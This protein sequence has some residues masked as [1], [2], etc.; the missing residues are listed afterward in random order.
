MD[1]RLYFRAFETEDLELINRLRNDDYVYELTSGNKYYVSS[2]RDER[3]IED[4]ILNNFS[5]LY[6]MICKYETN[7]PIGYIA[8]TDIDYVNRKAK[9]GGIVISK[10]HSHQGFGTEATELM[11]EHMFDELG[12]NMLY[13]FWREDHTSSIKM[14]EKTGFAI[15]GLITDYVYKQGKFHNAYLMTIT[16]KDYNKKYKNI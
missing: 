4:K 2:K 11:F 1:R 9:Y 7:E 14:A 13:G 3:W 5:Q 12:M 16:Q 15:N 6:L 10:E 8:V